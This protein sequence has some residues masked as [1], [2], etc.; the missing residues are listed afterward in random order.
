MRKNEEE[1]KKLIQNALDSKKIISLKTFYLSDY[2]EMVLREIAQAV[3]DK[4]N[5][6]EL[7]SIVY[8]SAKELVINATKANL[9][10]IIF[11]EMKLDPSIPEQYEEGMEHFRGKLLEQEIKKYKNRF[12][13][14]DFP[15]VATF[16]YA[17]TVLNITVKNNFTMY[18]AEEERIREKFRKAKSFS[19]LL[20]FF[21]EHGDQTEG[22]GMGLT[23]VG[24]LLD[25]SGIDRH[26]FTV[27]SNEYNETAAKLEIPLD[28][29]Y[30]TKRSLFEQER[31][32]ANMSHDEFRKVYK[33]KVFRKDF[34]P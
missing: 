19:S 18:H 15:V 20:D 8:T 34:G 2:G 29:S 21:M 27:Y 32:K 9:K 7:M 24:I 12:I 4:L 3:L 25:E 16:Y 10:R 13:E 23:M 26:A 1:I 30:V 17:P 14:L 28:G 22:A 11:D 31:N 6:P 33:P 5:R